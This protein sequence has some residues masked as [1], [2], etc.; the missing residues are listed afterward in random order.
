MSLLPPLSLGRLFS[1]YMYM[2]HSNP[3][4]ILIFGIYIFLPT[5]SEMITMCRTL[6]SVCR[7]DMDE[8]YIY[9]YIGCVKIFVYVSITNSIFLYSH[10]AHYL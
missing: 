1:I 7:M 4:T 10:L 8:I 9:I 2:F 5:F 3:M 6:F